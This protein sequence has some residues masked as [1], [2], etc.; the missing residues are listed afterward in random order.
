MGLGLSLS[1]P[2]DSLI[3]TNV[4]VRNM[5]C[6]DSIHNHGIFGAQY[7]SQVANIDI[8]PNRVPGNSV[9]LFHNDSRFAIFGVG[10][11]SGG[12]IISFSLWIKT[13]LTSD[14]ILVHY[15]KFIKGK[16]HMVFFLSNGVPEFKVKPNRVLRAINTPSIAD[17]EWHH[18]AISMPSRSCRLSEIQMFIDG[19]AVETEANDENYYIFYQTA[20]SIA[21]GGFGYSSELF[22]T[23]YPKAVPFQ[24]MVDDFSLWSKPLENKIKFRR[25]M[26]NECMKKYSVKTKFKRYNQCKKKCKKEKNCHGFAFRK[27]RN[28]VSC[29]HLTDVQSSDINLQTIVRS[30]C[31]LKA[32]GLS[33][34]YYS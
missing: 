6:I 18:I 24:G 4:T 29:K 19:I 32:M 2:G 28:F 11:F 23:L 13:K 21:I 5:T 34:T 10:P 1:F 7:D 15:G 16:D 31:K 26:P 17:D 12:E 22:E 33:N 27:G 20:G 14:T 3:A 30:R 9:G 8:I 25:G